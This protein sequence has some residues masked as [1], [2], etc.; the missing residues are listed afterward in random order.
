MTPPVQ[1]MRLRTINRWL[2]AYRPQ[3]FKELTT[4]GRLDARALEMDDAMLEE[5]E[6]REHSLRAEL[7]RTKVWG[8]AKGMALYPTQRME[9]WNEVLADYLP[10]TSVP[11][12]ED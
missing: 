3:E 6:A 8:T 2:E 11:P 7:E 9:A 5:F 1:S 12:P 10:A 4:S